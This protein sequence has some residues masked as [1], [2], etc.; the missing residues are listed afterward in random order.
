MRYVQINSWYQYSTGSIMHGIDAERRSA[1]DETWMFWGRGHETIDEHAR[2]VGTDAGVYADALQTR[3]DGRA[4]FH[5]QVATKHLLTELDEIKPNIIHL[6]NVHGYYVNVEMLFAWL[7]CHDEVRVRWTLHDCWAFT[8]H[9][10][11]FTSAKCAQWRTHCAYFQKCPQ[12]DT[13]PKTLAG[14]RS[15]RW[16]FERKRAAFT[17]VSPERVTLVTPS[18]WLADLVKQSFLKEYPVEVRHNTID[19]TV[20]KP[21]ATDFRDSYNI[22]DRFMVLG[23]AS[24]WTERKGLGDFVRLAG[25]LDSERFAIVLVG[26]S[27]KQIKALPVGVVGLARTESPQEL[28]G[29][30]ST[31]DVFFNPTREDNYPTVNLEAEACGTPVVTYDTGGC[32]ETIARE[33]SNVVQ[34][35]NEATR[36]VLTLYGEGRA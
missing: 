24:T 25:D 5:S 11:Y 17:S 19:K 2:R 20:F 34:G 32:R 27:P 1:G 35:Y 23:V 33:D 4:G 16:C 13:Y 15:C 31:A 3:L 22:G 30:Y 36:A 10:A 6:H 9:C 7:T 29:I 14:S 8:G 26:L 21:T 28:A 12:L 18:Q